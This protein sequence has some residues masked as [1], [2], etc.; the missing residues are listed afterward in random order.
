[1]VN[2]TTLGVGFNNTAIIDGGTT[3]HIL[4]LNVLQRL[5]A[6]GIAP[7]MTTM[8]PGEMSIAFGREDNPEPVLGYITTEFGKIVIVNNMSAE[9]L[10]SEK[11]FTNIGACIVKDNSTLAIIFDNK[12]LLYGTRNAVSV[13]GS[14]EQLWMAQIDDMFKHPPVLHPCPDVPNPMG[15]MAS[16]IASATSTA[17]HHNSNSIGVAN[18]A[19]P[20]WTAA[21]FRQAHNLIWACNGSANK[22]AATLEANA[23]V[24]QPQIDP[25]LIRHIGEQR[26]DPAFRM[27]HDT[28]AHPGGIGG[29]RHGSRPMRLN[30]GLLQRLKI[31][32][33]AG[34]EI[35]IA[36]RCGGAG[37]AANGIGIGLYAVDDVERGT[38][39]PEMPRQQALPGE[40]RH[41]SSGEEG[42]EHRKHGDAMGGRHGA[43][44]AADRL[45]PFQDSDLPPR[46]REQHSRSQA[47]HAR[48]HDADA[49]RRLI[50]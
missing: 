45:G 48:P 34:G 49:V 13:P 22:L 24:R 15:A 18:A 9:A 6:K 37:E 16:I 46:S 30:E 28:L 17:Q 31:P 8:Q 4:R 38:I 36:L 29:Q 32:L 14:N 10:L 12:L 5:Q 33:P 2:N 47:P 44:L 1:M 19:K 25:Q 23:M 7:T 39:G 41:G 27:T 43:G 20:A 42:L 11:E 3:E 35:P 40:R 21:Q 50:H 26:N